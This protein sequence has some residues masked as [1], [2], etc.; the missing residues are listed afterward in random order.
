MLLNMFWQ[1]LFF[2]NLQRFQGLYQPLGYVLAHTEANEQPGSDMFSKT[3]M[4]F[5]HLNT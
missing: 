5:M 2:V 1:V 4:K 3:Q